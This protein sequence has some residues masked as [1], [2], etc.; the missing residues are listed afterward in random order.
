L[1]D[2]E[3]EVK[4]VLMGFLSDPNKSRILF[5]W[6]EERH[7]EDLYDIQNNEKRIEQIRTTDPETHEFL[8]ILKLIFKNQKVNTDT[9]QFMY[10]ILQILTQ[11]V[12]KQISEQTYKPELMLTNE[13][14]KSLTWLN[15]FFKR[16]LGGDNGR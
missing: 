4:K 7:K 14:R 10:Y 2:D 9:F 13:D 12:Q 6:L 8:G 3:N 5:K 11:S 15:E 1:S 16:A